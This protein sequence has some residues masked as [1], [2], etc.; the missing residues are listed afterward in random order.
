M[1]ARACHKKATIRARPPVPACL[2]DGPPGPS[3]RPFASAWR[4]AGPASTIAVF[5]VP[6]PIGAIGRDR[7][8]DAANR[9]AAVGRRPRFPRSASDY[10]HPRGTAG[11]LDRRTI[12]KGEG[13]VVQRIPGRRPSGSESPPQA[14]ARGSDAGTPGIR[15][16]GEFRGA[17]RTMHDVRVRLPNCYAPAVPKRRRILA[18]LPT[19]RPSSTLATVRQLNNRPLARQF[20]RSGETSSASRNHHGKTTGYYL[21]PT[22]IESDQACPKA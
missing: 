8:R 15:P 13:P 4:Q 7:R 14:T 12:G 6:S 19:G 11:T 21:P 18:D 9:R 20:P 2:A 3:T 10:G 5:A 17:W 22:R 16:P 1:N